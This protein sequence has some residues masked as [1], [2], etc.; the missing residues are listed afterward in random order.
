MYCSQCGK[1]ISD[2]SKFCNFCGSKI[3][4]VD[5]ENNFT[6]DDL[7]INACKDCVEKHLK[8]PSTVKYQSITIKDYDD[9]GRIYL[10][11]ELDSQNGFGAYVRNK[12]R[13]VLQSV[14]DD[15]GYEAL[16]ESVYKESFINT[17]DVVKRVNKWN[18]KK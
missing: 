16:N 8:A 17:E 5:K 12:L 10:S 2:N 6:K 14:N 18:K 13:V 9:Y 3:E 7:I 4:Q 1:E 15:G 11:V